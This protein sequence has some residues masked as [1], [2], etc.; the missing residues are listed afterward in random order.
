MT[1]LHYSMA[2][3]WS[4]D[5]EAFVVSLP[6]FGDAKTHG[7]TYKEAVQN[8]EEVLELLIQ[9]YQQQGNQLPVPQVVHA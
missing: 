4:Q 5:D 6:E 9:T 1:P 7:A 3:Q 8:A 2:I